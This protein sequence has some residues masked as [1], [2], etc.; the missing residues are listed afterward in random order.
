LNVKSTKFAVNNKPCLIYRRK[1]S[2]LKKYLLSR[3]QSGG[4]YVF[5]GL[6]VHADTGSPA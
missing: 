1:I 4:G 6:I 3:L 2:N 5:R